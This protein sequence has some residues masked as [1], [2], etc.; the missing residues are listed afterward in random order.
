MS[1]SELTRAALLHNDAGAVISECGRYRYWL[2]RRWMFGQGWTV[3]IILNP[4]TADAVFDDPTIRRC[5]NFAKDFGSMGLIVV[6]LFAWRATDPRELLND[7]IDATGPEN[8]AYVVRA[9]E[10]AARHED[11]GMGG[12]H[13]P[14]K[15]ICAWG[16][17][18]TA[19]PQQTKEL[20]GWIDAAH[21][22]AFC[23]GLTKSGLPRHP[24]YVAAR[25]EI[26]PYDGP[27]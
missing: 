27:R 19:T 11:D 13:I 9:C 7:K 6:N 4:S 18:P 1:V 16:A 2:H 10:L 23:L 26:V 24:L 22:Q 20:M 12:M 17:H 25:T 15:V 21:G 14:G 5:I 3:F 8:H